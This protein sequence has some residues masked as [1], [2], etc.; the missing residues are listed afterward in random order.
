V[1]KLCAIGFD[2]LQSTLIL[3]LKIQNSGVKVVC[4]I[5]E[6]LCKSCTPGSCH[7]K[8]EDSI[9]RNQLPAETGT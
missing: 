6:N 2:I 7:E 3:I 4:Q 5:P 8:A 9:L 1:E